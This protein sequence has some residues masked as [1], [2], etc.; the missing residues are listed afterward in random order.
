VPRL[1]PIEQPDAP[2]E[3]QE[4]Y[5]TDIERYG[6]VLNNTKLYTH[7]VPVL[8]A[9]KGFVGAFAAAT[10]IPMGQKALIRVRVALLNGCPF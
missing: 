1:E 10:A 7:S 5:E 3:A 8:K 9:I 6:E 2:A 4:Y